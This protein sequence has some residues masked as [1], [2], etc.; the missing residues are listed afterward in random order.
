MPA[1]LIVHNER[2]GEDTLL[3]D[4]PLNFELD[5]GWIVFHDQHGPCYAVPRE[6]VRNIMRIDPQQN[7]EP[8][9]EGEP[10]RR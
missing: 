8:D 3:E 2:R 7:D 9:Q 4:D 1:Y 6:Q 10:D 5:D